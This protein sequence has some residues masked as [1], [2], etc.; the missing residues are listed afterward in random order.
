MAH[1]Q[2]F[3]ANRKVKNAIAG[4]ENLLIMNNPRQIIQ[5]PTPKEPPPVMCTLNGILSQQ[6]TST[7]RFAQQ[8]QEICI[9]V[10]VDI[11]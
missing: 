2:S 6:K 1:S 7:V 4:A 8:G 9:M 11:I 5:F 3:L 10:S